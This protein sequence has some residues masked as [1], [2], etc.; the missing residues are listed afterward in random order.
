MSNL[1]DALDRIKETK[2][3]I[4]GLE[5][6]RAELTVIQSDTEDQLKTVDSDLAEARRDLQAGLQDVNDIDVE[7][8]RKV[9]ID[10][11]KEVEVGAEMNP[12]GL[13]DGDGTIPATRP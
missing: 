1:D 2:L 13:P 7:P 6:R 3:K 10:D 5:D 9:D 12:G 4:K 11:L 8:E